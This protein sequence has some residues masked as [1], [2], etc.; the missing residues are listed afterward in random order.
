M[1]TVVRLQMSNCEAPNENVFQVEQ[2]SDARIGVARRVTDCPLCPGLGEVSLS[3]LLD[4]VSELATLALLLLPSLCN[5]QVSPN[6]EH[7]WLP[8]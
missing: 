7:T 2:T 6:T 4:P 5:R 1:C 3:G 8:L